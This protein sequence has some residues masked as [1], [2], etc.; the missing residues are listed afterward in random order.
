MWKISKTIGLTVFKINLLVLGKYYSRTLIIRLHNNL[1]FKAKTL[2]LDN[3]PDICFRSIL[4]N[5]NWKQTSRLSSIKNFMNQLQY[6]TYNRQKVVISLLYK[7][8]FS[9][10]CSLTSFTERTRLYKIVEFKANITWM[11]H[12]CVL[13]R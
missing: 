11:C 2:R 4:W 5:I 13:Y 3:L 10:H 6:F 9:K 1:A 12:Y 7:L 8:V